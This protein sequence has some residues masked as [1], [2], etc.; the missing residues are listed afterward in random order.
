MA[1]WSRGRRATPRTRRV[2]IRRSNKSETVRDSV[3]SP[4]TRAFARRCCRPH[5][6]PRGSAPPAFDPAA[7]YGPCTGTQAER[8][9]DNS[10]DMGTGYR[11]LLT[12]R[13][14]THSA[15]DH[16]GTDR[17]PP[18]A[19]RS[20]AQA[21]FYELQT[22]MVAFFAIA[23]RTPARPTIFPS[24]RASARQLVQGP[25][26]IIA[27]RAPASRLASRS[28][29]RLRRSPRRS[30]PSRSLTAWRTCILVCAKAAGDSAA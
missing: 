17:Q 12:C 21:R 4:A 2:S 13:S 27:R 11:L 26:N 10:L 7:Q 1:A 3:T 29:S 15:A 30:T 22:R 28:P 8:A 18:P 14:H 6:V 25:R 16:A 20:N 9:P 24:R 23:A 5:L 19:V